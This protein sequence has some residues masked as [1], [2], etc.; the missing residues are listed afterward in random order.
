MTAEDSY[1]AMTDEDLRA[2]HLVWSARVA[3]AP[4]PASA[5]FAAQQVEEITAEG[6]RRG[7]GLVNRHK[8]LGA[9]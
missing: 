9:A 1:A 7:L 6:K 2:A 3:E 5:Y 4:G 8:I